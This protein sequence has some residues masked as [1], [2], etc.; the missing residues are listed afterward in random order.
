MP[1]LDH[2]NNNIQQHQDHNP[3]PPPTKQQP[4]PRQSNETIQT[5]SKSTDLIVGPL[6]R[7]N[8]A[9]APARLA[10][11]DIALLVAFV[12][13]PHQAVGGP[14]VREQKL[15][16]ERQETV[17]KLRILLVELDHVD[18]FVVAHNEGGGAMFSIRSRWISHTIQTSS[19]GRVG[20][21]P[22]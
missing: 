14:L 21:F 17:V 9:R 4:Q 1:H 22:S 2:N 18:L 11:V 15:Q 7:I 5:S 13:V 3:T 8:E 10:L 6:E 16:G 20:V 12:Q 19:L